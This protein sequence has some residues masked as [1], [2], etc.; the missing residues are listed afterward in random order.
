MARTIKQPERIAIMETI[1]ITEEAVREHN[2]K[3]MTT[4]DVKSFILN[5]MANAGKMEQYQ[6]KHAFRKAVMELSLN[7]FGEYGVLEGAKDP[8]NP[9]V[10]VLSFIYNT[11]LRYR[12]ELY[13]FKFTKKNAGRNCGSTLFSVVAIANL[14]ISCKDK[15]KNYTN[16]TETVKGLIDGCI[17]SHSMAY[18]NE[19][20][21][22]LTRM[23]ELNAM[24]DEWFTLLGEG[25]YSYVLV[26]L[27]NLSEEERHIVISMI[28]RKEG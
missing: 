2:L 14:W 17:N 25:K 4:E 5:Y 10:F 6:I 21:R 16:D 23:Y 26:Q 11:G 18:K 12:H 8:H 15:V 1:I 24:A 19:Q 9:H 7:L 13:R 3:N 22:K 27:N 20:A 28:E